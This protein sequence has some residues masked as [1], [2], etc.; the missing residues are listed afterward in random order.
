MEL[1]VLELRKRGWEDGK[2]MGLMSRGKWVR[3]VGARW[4]GGRLA[5]VVVGGSFSGHN[6]KEA[7][8]EKTVGELEK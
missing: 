5:M 6:C 7:C 1:Q 4:C 8:E 3:N 2:R